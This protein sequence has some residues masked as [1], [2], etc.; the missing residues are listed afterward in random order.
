MA[1]YVV[2]PKSD[3]EDICDSVRAK[4][5][6]NEALKSG[7]VSTEI[8]N[9]SLGI[10]TSDATASTGE[11][12][13][14][15]TAYV[16]GVKVTGT[17]PNRGAVSVSLDTGTTSYSVPAGYHNG[18]GKLSILLQEKTATPSTSAQTITPSSG[19]VLS[20]VMVEAISTQE[21]T[22]TPSTSAQTVTPDSGKYLSKVTVEACGAPKV[23]SGSCGEVG[24]LTLTLSGWTKINRIFINVKEGA[25]DADGAFQTNCGSA[26]SY[27]DLGLTNGGSTRLPGVKDG[28]VS[29]EW[30]RHILN[31][32]F[33]NS[34]LTISPNAGELSS[35]EGTAT[36]YY[37]IIGE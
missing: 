8:D 11:I 17:M 10:D 14:G 32:A 29:L 1:D 9:I 18:G 35:Y 27:S 16:N 3:Y 12:L 23:V 31:A 19:K 6:K 21:K 15:E 22:V 33:L 7:E 28:V 30:Y 5:G 26:F 24:T 4:T 25:G 37:Y 36:F 20:K 2:M 13:A 34:V